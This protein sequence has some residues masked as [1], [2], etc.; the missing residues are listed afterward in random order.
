MNIPLDKK[1]HFVSGLIIAFVV[2]LLTESVL[3]G[4]AAAIGAELV[5]IL[6]W[7]MPR[8]PTMDWQEKGFDMLAQICGAAAGSLFAILLMRLV[9]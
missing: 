7:D 3:L 8:T 9:G 5:K 4:C 6:F 2:R 1:L